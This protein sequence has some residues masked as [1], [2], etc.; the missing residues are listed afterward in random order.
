M[1]ENAVSS[2]PI[3]ISLSTPRRRSVTAVR[4]RSSGFVVGLA[5]EVPM[6]EPPVKWMHG[7]KPADLPFEQPTVM[8]FVVNR[9]A[10]GDLGL[11]IS[12][13]VGALVTRWVD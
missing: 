5:R 2:P 7:A 1:A 12:S 4:S 13:E 10:L 3:V 8:E 6:Y 9:R 11:S